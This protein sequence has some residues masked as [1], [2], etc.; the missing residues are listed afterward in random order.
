MNALRCMLVLVISFIKVIPYFWSLSLILTID[1]ALNM[2]HHTFALW[3]KRR[4][5]KRNSFNFSKR[6]WLFSICS[7]LYIGWA[8]K[9]LIFLQRHIVS[10]EN[11]SSISKLSQLFDGWCFYFDIRIHYF[12][13]RYIFGASVSYHTNASATKSWMFWEMN[14]W[15]LSHRFQRSVTS[16]FLVRKSKIQPF[17]CSIVDR[18]IFDHSIVILILLN[19]G[20]INIF[21]IICGNPTLF[22]GHIRFGSVNFHRGR[23]ITSSPSISTRPSLKQRRFL[24]GLLLNLS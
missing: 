8:I 6:W 1:L 12:P 18:G 22:Y 16:T 21:S 13:S 23:L 20:I 19:S 14:R 7:L 11:T 9:I 24:R 5:S 15:L 17:L 10:L 4:R 2:G 3:L